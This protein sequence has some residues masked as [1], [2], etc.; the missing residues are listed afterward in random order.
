MVGRPGAVEELSR[1]VDCGGFGKLRGA[2]DA[3]ATEPCAI[4]SSAGKVPPR[5][6]KPGQRW[7]AA[8]RRGTG[9]AWAAPGVVAFSPRIRGDQ[10]RKRD[11]VVSHAALHVAG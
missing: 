10:L 2:V 7:R 3:G 4:P 1:S 11:V 9:D 8:A 5:P 6:A